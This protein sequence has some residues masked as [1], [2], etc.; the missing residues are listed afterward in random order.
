VPLFITN[1]GTELYGIWVLSNIILGYADIFDFGF[2]KGLQKYVAEAR[3][4]G[5][6]EELSQV[7]VTG[8]ALL[9][10]MGLLIGGIIFIFSQPIITF[11]NISD[12]HIGIAINLLKI[13]AVFS[14]IIW[15]LRITDVILSASM[16]IKEE[17][18]LNAIRYTAQS[19]IVLF[20]VYLNFP[21]VTI[22][23]IT[24]I[25][26]TVL[27]LPAIIVAR[28][29]VPEVEW[30]LKSVR[31]AQIKRMSGFSFG[32]FHLSLLAMLSTKVDNIILGQML[33]MT[34]VAIYAIISKPYEIIKMLSGLLMKTLMPVTYNVIPN[35]TKEE[36]EDL[37]YSAVK[38]RT[39]IDVSLSAV[40]IVVLPSFINLWVGQEYM[41]Y[42]IWGQLFASIHLFMGLASLG[43][44]AR[45]IGAMSLVNS[46]LTIKVLVNVIISIIMTKVMG[47]GGV[48]IG[49]FLS[50]ALFG[51][52][53]FGKFISKKIGINHN[54]IIK[55]FIGP[56]AVGIIF[57]FVLLIQNYKFSTWMS[58][59]FGSGV[60][61]LIL[62]TVLLFLFM[63]DERKLIKNKINNFSIKKGVEKK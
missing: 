46:M 30:S 7:V 34:S 16:K 52:I 10:L 33:G 28:R 42:V 3:V 15:P 6:K 18:L 25:I 49:T 19:V 39:L 55:A 27:S 41:Q 21:I 9:S 45:A 43:N 12:E 56:V 40:T 1:L 24:M 47:F 4:K 57:I 58:L 36:K 32:M 5:D 63:G 62:I 14:V 51:E 23:I 22:K 11:F 50:N 60:L 37:I 53:I 35:A 31:I 29:A 8:L 2:T 54:R 61:F 38:Y 59:I 13:S 26:F 48:I 20:M 44:V 17:S